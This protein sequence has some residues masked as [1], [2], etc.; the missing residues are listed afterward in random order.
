MNVVM[1]LVP[2]LL[3]LAVGFFVGKKLSSSKAKEIDEAAKKEAEI[4]LKKANTEAEV[5]WEKQ[6]KKRKYQAK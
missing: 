1:I 5:I 2:A 4:I 3:T 6:V